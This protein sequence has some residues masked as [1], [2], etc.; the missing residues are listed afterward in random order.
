MDHRRKC[1]ARH[2]KTLR[3]KQA[4]G[5]LTFV[6][7]QPLSLVWLFVTPQTAA[8]QAS[9]SLPSPG[10]YSNSWPLS[11]W[12]HPT[13][14]HSVALFSSWFKIFPESW[15]FRINQLYASG[16]VQFS[17]VQSLSRVR[18]FTTPWTVVYR[19]L[20]ARILEWVAFPFARYLPNPGIKSRSPTLQVDSLPSEPPGKPNVSTD[21]P[22][23]Y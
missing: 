16:S 22:K 20:Q 5:Y 21:I 10:V 18:L 17:S 14:S 7:V 3:G 12:C 19:I 13:N 1:K 8:C 15:N 11:Q 2:D 6:V 4:E 9:L 23:I